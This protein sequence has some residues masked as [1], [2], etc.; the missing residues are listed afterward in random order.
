VIFAAPLD[1]PW[2][3]RAGTTLIG[4]GGGLFASAR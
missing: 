3:F 4:F 2:L 1:S